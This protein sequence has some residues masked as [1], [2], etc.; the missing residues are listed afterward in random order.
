MERRLRVATTSAALA[1]ALGVRL[2]RCTTEGSARRVRKA[3]L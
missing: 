3:G 1:K 2:P